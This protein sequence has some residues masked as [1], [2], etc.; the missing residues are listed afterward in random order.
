MNRANDSQEQRPKGTM[1]AENRKPIES[2]VAKDCALGWVPLMLLGI[3]VPWGVWTF[4]ALLGP[5]GSQLVA[6]DAAAGWFV[7][8]AIGYLG[9]HGLSRLAWCSVP[10]LLTFRAVA[11]FI[12]VP[13]WRFAAGDVLVDSIYVQAMFLTLIGFAAFWIGSLLFMKEARL[14]FV[15]REQDTSSRVAFMS[16]TMLGLGLAGNLVT[17]KV[18]LFSYTADAGLRESSFPIMQWLAFFAN[19]LNAALVVSAIEVL[20]KR[21]T[22]SVINIVFWLSAIFSIGFGA[23][24]GMKEEL[25]KP[26][27]YLLLVYGITRARIPR[28]ALLL[29][30]LL[31]LIYPFVNAY[32]E[33]LNNGYRSQVNTI[34]GLQ[35]TVVKSFNDVIDAPVSTNEQVGKGFTLATDRLS[36]LTFVHDIVGL[37]APSLLNGDEKIWL[38]PLY[39]L[40]PR[41]LWIDKPVLN[42]GQR[43]SLA[44]GRPSTTS[45]AVTPIGDLY[46]IYGAY[47]VV[48]GMFIYGV[49]LQTYMNSAIRGHSERNLFIYI[50]M[51]VPLINLEQD[52]VALVAGAV[53]LGIVLVLT[54]Y[55]IYGGPFSPKQAAKSPRSITAS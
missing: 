48:V 15:P 50:L 16:A 4:C 25:L 21:S 6:L 55:A 24:S 9:L 53:Q 27:I 11:E 13:A 35:A 36:L 52:T 33:N 8:L 23:I 51:I 46:S 29:P 31:L 32:R 34:E 20:G 1:R 18:G 45:S 54:S 10:V 22:K 39:P 12:C 26:L 37:P 2:G 44:L 14:R 17:W 28:T 7:V 3:G 49:C 38:A 43:L 42:K 41:M 19:L 47:G 40:V 30:M 5:G